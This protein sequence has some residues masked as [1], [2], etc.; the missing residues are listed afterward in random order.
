M[1]TYTI[2]E[3]AELTGLS[4]KAMRHRVDRGQLRA[5]KYDG[6]RR[7]SRSE[8]ERV[9][10]QVAPVD[11]VSTVAVGALRDRLRE[12]EREL[13]AL[14]REL[15]AERARRT[16]VQAEA[17]RALA[18]ERADRVEAQAQAQQTLAESAAVREWREALLRASPIEQ[19]R[20]IR[21]AARRARGRDLL[22]PL[23]AIAGSW[24]VAGPVAP[25]AVPDRVTGPKR[26]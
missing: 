13:D 2:A 10:L 5:L 7:I 9:G 25:P 17:E 23:R 22:Q 6:V 24:R 8:L 19:G 21:C 1:D 4:K 15:E 11:P 16:E 26:I 14:R 12:R 18:A 3:A 20:L